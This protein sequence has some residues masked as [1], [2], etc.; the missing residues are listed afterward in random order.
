MIRVRE[1]IGCNLDFIEE[2]SETRSDSDD[3][4]SEESTLNTDICSGVQ[5]KGSKES[6]IKRDMDNNTCDMIEE[7]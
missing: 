3:D 2:D 4:E 1:I 5:G 6:E 7:E